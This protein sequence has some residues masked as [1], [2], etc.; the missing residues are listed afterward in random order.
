M[1]LRIT[2][3]VLLITAVIVGSLLIWKSTENSETSE[4]RKSQTAT[5]VGVSTETAGNLTSNDRYNIFWT[6]EAV[7]EGAVAFTTAPVYFPSLFRIE[8]GFAIPD[9]DSILLLHQNLRDKDVYPIPGLNT[10]TQSSSAS[11]SNRKHG[12]YLFNIGNSTAPNARK[13]ISFNSDRFRIVDRE[14]YAS[15]LTACDDGTVKWLEFTPDNTTAAQGPGT[16]QIVTWRADDTLEFSKISWE[17]SR[18]P[19]HE[20]QLSCT[21]SLSRIISEDDSG[22]PLVLLLED[23]GKVTHVKD[24]IK[25][26]NPSLPAMARF[27][28]VFQET[29]YSFDEQNNLTAIDLATGR[30]IYKKQ[31]D[32]KGPS[33]VSITFDND[34]AFLVIRPDRFDNKQAVLPIDLKNPQCTGAVT[35]LLGYEDTSQISKIKR[36]GDSFMVATSVLPKDSDFTINCEGP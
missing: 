32:V 36:L 7:D 31:I 5:F 10:G 19:G 30:L 23:R 27:S 20:N 33:P 18:E 1:K 22:N 24:E 4:T 15:A 11:S 28:T 26:S 17:F 2:V 29:F 34:Y 13:L 9:S 8:T 6:S 12:V 25:I 3:S 21:S 35:P 16:A 14:K